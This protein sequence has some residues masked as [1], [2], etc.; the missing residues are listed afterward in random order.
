M[1]NPVQDPQAVGPVD[2]L[3]NCAGI[4]QTTILKRTP[5]AELADILGTN[6]AATML[7]CK[8]A[9]VQDRGE[10]THTR[11]HTHKEDRV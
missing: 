11:T 6:L 4:S 3:V 2:I 1:S 5:D 8:Y 7:V 10:H 9:K